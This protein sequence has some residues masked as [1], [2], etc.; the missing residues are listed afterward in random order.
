MARKYSHQIVKED[1]PP[2][3]T[4]GP[5]PTEKQIIQDFTQATKLRPQNARFWQSLGDARRGENWYKQDNPDFAPAIAAYQ[6]SLKLNNSNPSLWYR[7]YQIVRQTDPAL[8]LKAMRQAA[9]EDGGNA[10]LLYRLAGAL[11]SETRAGPYAKPIQTNGVLESKEAATKRSLSG[12]E[13]EESKRKSEEAL[14]LMERGNKMPRY[15]PMGYVSAAPDLLETAW[16]FQPDYAEFNYGLEELSALDALLQSYGKTR[17]KENNTATAQRA[18][19]ALLGMGRLRLTAG[20]NEFSLKAV[21]LIWVLAAM[22]N[23]ERRLRF[24]SG[25]LSG[26]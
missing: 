2:K 26:E 6:T 9:K 1:D 21:D 23:V 19:D 12:T 8:A 17:L 3:E 5:L 13:T 24:G 25:N 16:N 20:M 15:K 4:G 10:Y 22:S 18:A 7:I 14:S 11:L